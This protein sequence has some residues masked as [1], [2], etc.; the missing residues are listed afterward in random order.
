MIKT[1]LACAALTLAVCA[2]APAL[3]Q[4]HTA[5]AVSACDE[6]TVLAGGGCPN[7]QSAQF[8]HR[9]PDGSYTDNQGHTLDGADRGRVGGALYD[10]Y[11][12]PNADFQT[13]DW[14]FNAIMNRI[15]NN[16]GINACSSSEE[17][18]YIRD[19]VAS[20]PGLDDAVRA[21]DLS[22]TCPTEFGARDLLGDGG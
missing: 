5:D 22:R 8:G 3:A 2:G 18:A 20:H 16:P 1:L 15:A 11:A 4:E 17:R 21:H 13:S 6:A 14:R 19:Y 7:N 12:R 9:N 10:V